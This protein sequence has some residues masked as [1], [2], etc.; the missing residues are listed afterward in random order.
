MRD[1]NDRGQRNIQAV[2]VGFRLI[3]AL[4]EAPGSMSL[5]S[6]SAA[7]GMTASKAHLYLVS[8]CNL[9]LVVQETETGYYALGPYALQLGLTALSKVDLVHHARKTLF[10]LR[11]VTGEAAYLSIH[12]NI[13]PCI[14]KKV[15]GQKE[16]P[17]VIRVGFTL[18]LTA[19]ATGRVY[20]AFSN[21]EWVKR[22]VE[23][24]RQLAGRSAKPKFSAAELSQIVKS[25]KA[26]GYAKTESLLNIGHAALSAPIFDHEGR[27]AG[28]LTLLGP[29]S[30]FDR[31][32]ELQFSELLLS[33][34]ASLSAAIGYRNG[35][36]KHSI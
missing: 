33:H 4:E 34:A 32:T 16:V 3:R 13:G 15:D 17:L 20:L 14:I 1:Q 30:D 23:I 6:L 27:L 22:N 26:R 18:P 9:G 5:K 7:A 35:S 8:F 11:D 31:E 25:V 21:Q 29:A 2:E 28:A 19:S 36:S 24:E 12:G 10:D